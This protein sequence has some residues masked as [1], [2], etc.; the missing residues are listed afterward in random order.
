MLE[1]PQEIKRP[2]SVE[3]PIW[4]CDRQRLSHSLRSSVLTST[5][6]PLEDLFRVYHA[7]QLT[8]CFSGIHCKYV[9]FSRLRCNT[10]AVYQHS[11]PSS[12]LISSVSF[13]GWSAKHTIAY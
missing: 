12:T 7:T 10:K 5:P 3:K 1:L 11:K 6:Y 4:W 9:C 13:R 2:I 8:S